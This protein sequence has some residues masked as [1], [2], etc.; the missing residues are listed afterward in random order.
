MKTA[1]LGASGYAGSE[2]LRLM[3]TH[4]ELDL[5]LATADSAA[6]TAI[7]AHVPSL[8][9][10]YG[11][12]RFEEHERIYATDAE[13]VFCALP[14][15]LSQRFVARLHR[16]GR[17]V[18]DLGADFRLKNV[19][20]YQNWY[21]Q[22]HTAA[23]LLESAVYA[24]VERHRVELPGSRLL[25]IPGCFP[26]A[27]VLALG[28]F[29]DAGWLHPTGN[30][31]NALSGASG[32]GRATSDRLHFSRLHA[33]AEPYG[34]LTHRHTVEME[35]E[36]SMQILFTPHLVAA[37]RGLLVTAYGSMRSPRTTA[38]AMAVLHERYDA[39]PFV[40]VTEEPPALKD[41]LGSNL[42]FVTA[43]VDERT[44]WLVAM[45]SID[46]LTKGASGQALQALNVAM[47][48]PESWGLSNTGVAP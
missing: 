7:G 37:T 32:A 15:G 19:A 36:L 38:E 3:V 29:A 43:R 40:V 4:P 25:A 41:P 48:W 24:L 46:N 1:L 9:G 14:H 47:G 26:T 6:G 44:G 39:E 28:P 35:Q 22:E 27:T 10:A 12:W 17:I 8:A 5:T 2:L 30:V 23:S 18:V 16:E 11:E 45:S 20:D 42:C 31:V 13:L 34:L 21:Q 33:N